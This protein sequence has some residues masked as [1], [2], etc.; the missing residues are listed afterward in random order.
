MEKSIVIPIAHSVAWTLLILN[1]QII[2]GALVRVH[3]MKDRLPD[4]I[5]RFI[6]TP[7]AAKGWFGVCGFLIELI[8]LWGEY[9]N[10]LG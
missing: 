8:I 7:S 4:W 2:D 3:G 6:T 5:L 9:F 1:T 10:W